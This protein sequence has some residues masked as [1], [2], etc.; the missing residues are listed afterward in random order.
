MVEKENEMKGGGNGA[1]QNKK[2]CGEKY[3]GRKKLTVSLINTLTSEQKILWHF[4]FI[5]LIKF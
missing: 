2:I 1:S 5:Y 3:L 4:E